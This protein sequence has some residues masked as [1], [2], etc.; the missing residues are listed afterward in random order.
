[1]KA[2]DLLQKGFA[3]MIP[4]WIPLKEDKSIDALDEGE[5]PGSVQI[6]VAFGP[7]EDAELTK[8]EWKDCVQTMKI[9]QAY[10]LRVHLYQGRNLPAADDNGLSDPYL[11]VT[12]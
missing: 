4:E 5:F 10:Q 1:L 2:K 3:N 8:K 7:S 11:K 6:L 9:R 12:H